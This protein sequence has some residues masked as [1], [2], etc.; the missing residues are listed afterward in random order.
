MSILYLIFI[1]WLEFDEDAQKILIYSIKN[2]SKV[3]D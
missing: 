2:R 1:H 3:K